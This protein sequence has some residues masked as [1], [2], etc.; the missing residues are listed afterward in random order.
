MAKR[1][2]EEAAAYVEENDIKFIR[3]AFCDITGRHKNIAIMPRELSAAFDTGIGIDYAKIAGGTP[4]FPE[5]GDMLYLRPDPSTLTILPWR[6]QTGRVAR[7]YCNI[8]DRDGKPFAYDTRQTLKATL[9]RC[10][11]AGFSCRMGLRSEFYLFKADEDGNPTKTPWDNGGYLDVAPMDRAE[12]IR[13]EICLS[14]EEME[15][16]PESSHHEAGPGQNEI[17]FFAA[18][19]LRSADNFMTYRN[20]VSSI[21]AK[22]GGFA[23]FEPYPVP[24]QSGNG[25]HLKVT[26]HRGGEN[27]CESD[28]K[29]FSEFMGGV[30]A[31]IRDIT[32]FLNPLPSSYD[33][34]GKD[35]APKAIS[36]SEKNASRLLRLQKKADGRPDGFILRSPDPSVN[37]YLAFAMLLEAGL[38]GI[39][40]H[41]TLPAEEEKGQADRKN[42]AELPSSLREA[43]DTAKESS[44]IAS[45]GCKEIA[46]FYLAMEEH[47]AGA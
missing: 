44:F 35:E 3:L 29:L 23:S 22:N 11:E 17:D 16:P 36:W 20:V 4:G 1:T 19:A 40:N 25:L 9:T 34:F 28:P 31:C 24:G 46:A 6:P 5:I 30:Y 2:F 45:C 14:L 8:T 12:N 13:R 10:K 21:A 32:V 43:V 37:P 15:I 26:L 42:K 27:I 33:R 7:F 41:L 39:K 18:D 47:L 38:Y